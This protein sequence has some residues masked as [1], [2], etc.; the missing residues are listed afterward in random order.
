MSKRLACLRGRLLERE[1]AVGC[2]LSGLQQVEACSPV[3]LIF[4]STL[5]TVIAAVTSMFRSGELFC[6]VFVS[7]DYHSIEPDAL[8]RAAEKYEN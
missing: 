1:R 8:Q 6:L 3:Y 5:D 4:F 2:S 7:C